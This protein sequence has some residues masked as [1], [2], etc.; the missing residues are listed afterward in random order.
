MVIRHFEVI[1]SGGRGISFNQDKDVRATFRVPYGICTA[2][3]YKERQIYAETFL[4]SNGTGVP[5]LPALV[6]VNP[7]TLSQSNFGFC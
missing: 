4:A 1:S 5:L 2:V 6:R 7:K 3:F